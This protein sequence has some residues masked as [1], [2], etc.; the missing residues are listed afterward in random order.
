IIIK[1]LTS[2]AVMAANGSILTNKYSEG[3]PRAQYYGG[4]KFIDK[5][6][7]LCQ[8]QAL[9]AFR[10]DPQVWG[11]SFQ[12]YSGSTANFATFT[13]LIEPQ[14]QIMGLGLPDGGHLTHSFYTAK[15]KISASSIYFQSFPYSIDPESKLIDYEYLEKMAKIYKPRILIYGASAYPRDWDYKQLRKIADDQGAYLMMDVR[16]NF[17]VIFLYIKSIKSSLGISIYEVRD[18]YIQE[19]ILET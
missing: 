1:S 2:L 17:L 10:L 11:V 6:E 16:F 9:E 7:I 12:P 4:N 18:T 19:D 13:A 5:L 14:D 15:R 3:L 8:N